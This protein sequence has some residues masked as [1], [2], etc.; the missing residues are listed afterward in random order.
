MTAQLAQRIPSQIEYAIFDMDGLLI[1]S[2]RIY[3]EVTNAILS[4]YGHTMTWD[5][6]AGVM[7]KP[8]RIAA[9][10]ILS[11]FPDILEKLTVEEF[12]A[13]GVQR[14]EE[15]FKRVEPMRG[16]AEL[17]KGLHA[18]GIPI[19]LATG[20][21]MPNFIHKTTHLPHIFSLFPPTSILTADSPEVKRG[22]PN[23]DI[24]LA[25]AHSLGRDV[26]TAD[27]CT[28]EQKAERSRGLVFE[29]AR[30]GVL[31]GIAAGMNVIWVPDAELLA[32]NPEET[33]GAK[34]VLTHLEEWDPTRW[35]LPPLPG[36]NHIPAQ[37]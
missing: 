27:E 32:L 26:G 23:P 22:K 8:Q 11:H 6:K 16:A 15:L 13:E 7:G 29:D 9:E 37:P 19:A 31:A 20:S 3:T 24:F 1:D 30:P 36:F 5:I 35:G 12:I 21:T 25:A 4:R 2:E 10:Y 34:E 17:V 14:R 33:Y 28:E 18:A